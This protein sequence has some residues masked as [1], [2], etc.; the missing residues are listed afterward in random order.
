M[1]KEEP[2][3]DVLRSLR[4][5][6]SYGRSRSNSVVKAAAIWVSSTLPLV[7]LTP[8]LSRFVELVALGIDGGDVLFR[9]MGFSGSSAW[10]L[11]PVHLGMLHVSQGCCMSPTDSLQGQYLTSS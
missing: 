7:S 6:A 3:I 4:L 11:R 1:V 8:P 2:S 5:L 9:G 10:Y